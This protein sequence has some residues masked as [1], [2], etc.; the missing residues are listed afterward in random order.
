MLIEKEHFD[1]RVKNFHFQSYSS[2]NLI[3]CSFTRKSFIKLIKLPF[4]I[5]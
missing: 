4:T 2:C 3:T 5:F 1:V